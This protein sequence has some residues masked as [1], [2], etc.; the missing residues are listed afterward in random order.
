MCQAAGEAADGFRVHPMRSP[1]CLRDVVRPAPD[2]G[3]RTRGMRVDDLE[4]Q[5]PCIA[6]FARPKRNAQL[7]LVPFS[8][9]DALQP[10]VELANL[11]HD[12]PSLARQGQT[13]MR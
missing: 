9:D 7:G 11:A 6:I 4:V 5:T 10:N 8:P 13:C 1:G 2:A 3:A 12:W